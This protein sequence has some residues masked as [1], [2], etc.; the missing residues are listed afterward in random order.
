MFTVFHRA[1][2]HRSV[3]LRLQH[4]VMGSTAQKAC[5]PLAHIQ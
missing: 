1:I 3:L 5:A 2:L 4:N